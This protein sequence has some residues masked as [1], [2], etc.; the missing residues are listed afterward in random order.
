MAAIF[1][2]SISPGERRNCSLVEA[3]AEPVT[4]VAHVATE[5]A[6][7]RDDLVRQDMARFVVREHNARFGSYEPISSA[8]VR[9]RAAHHHHGAPSL[10][11]MR[12][13]G[14]RT[15][16]VARLVLAQTTSQEGKGKKDAGG[17]PYGY[18]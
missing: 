7:A 4:S 9:A 17:P 6:R 10:G 11:R 5:P 2:V 14:S 13:G 3:L 1:E 12:D 8:S 15:R 16:R 18:G